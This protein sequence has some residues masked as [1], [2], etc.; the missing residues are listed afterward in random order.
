MD[1]IERDSPVDK[2][3]AYERDSERVCTFKEEQELIPC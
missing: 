1:V 2:D 3:T